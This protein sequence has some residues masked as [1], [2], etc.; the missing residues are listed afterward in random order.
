[1]KLIHLDFFVDRVYDA[2]QQRMNKLMSSLT[3]SKKLELF[4]YH[5]PM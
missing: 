2:Y 5:A 1:M 4:I 3:T